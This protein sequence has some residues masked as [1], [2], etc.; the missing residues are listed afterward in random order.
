[1]RL[2]SDLGPFW[3]R[4]IGLCAL[5]ALVELAYIAFVARHTTG[6]GDFVFYNQTSDLI[7]QGKGYINPFDLAFHGQSHATALH[8]P[9][10]PLLL[11]IVSAVSNEAAGVTRTT[12]TDHRLVGVVLAPVAILLMGLVARRVGGERLG[13][14]A[15]VVT[16]LY[17]G[18]VAMNG[19]T[20][21]ETLYGPLVAGLLLCA[22]WVHDRPS[23][24]SAAAFGVVLAVATLSRTETL[25]LL[26]LLGGPL[27]WRAGPGRRWLVAGVMVG[28]TVVVLAPWMVRNQVSFGEPA[29]TTNDGGTLL[30]A[31]CPTT[32]NGASRDLGG[33][34][35]KCVP[36]RPDLNEAQQSDFYRGRAVDFARAHADR[37]PVVAGVRFL[38]VWG[39]W[40]PFR[41]TQEGQPEW[42]AKVA[43]VF[44]LGLLVAAVFG[45]VLMRRR[46]R[47]VWILLMPLV[48]VCLVGLL[49][50]GL[51]RF[52]YEAELS[53]VVFASVALEWVGVRVAAWRRNRTASSAKA[54]AAQATAPTAT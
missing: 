45:F 31:D 47:T 14:I 5:G 39:L 18:F 43:E 37:L 9:A 30:G 24:R 1:M 44:Y 8:P 52:R 33:W 28:V 29:L 3:R 12:Y 46:R 13:L 4:L 26:V 49:V 40:Q 17:P 48:L 25:A 34:Q 38:R 7:A 35:L 36:N 10:W 42:V 21:S 19:S 6:A 11:S 54:A 16:A 23:W 15:A 53:L 27:A 50:Y 32:Y 41:Y 2:P 20:M 22:Y 51:P